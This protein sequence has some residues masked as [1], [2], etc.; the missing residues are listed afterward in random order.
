M[1][2]RAPSSA[3]SRLWPGSQ[4]RCRDSRKPIRR[5]R[6]H[7]EPVKAVRSPDVSS[8]I[9]AQG[10]DEVT[11]TPDRFAALMRED[12]VELGKVV[13]DSGAKAD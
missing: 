12:S 8:K 3:P 4:R 5:A 2:N 9:T 10:L 7:E 13:K 6:V 11:T 1:H